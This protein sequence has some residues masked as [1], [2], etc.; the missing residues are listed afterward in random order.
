[1][2]TSNAISSDHLAVALARFIGQV[3]KGDQGELFALIA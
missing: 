3:M 2:Q 1:M